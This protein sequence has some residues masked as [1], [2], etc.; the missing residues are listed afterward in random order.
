[1]SAGDLALESHERW[2]ARSGSR[3]P[4]DGVFEHRR[5]RAVVFGRGDQQAL[6]VDEGLF[7]FR[8]VVWHPLFAFE[9]S[10]IAVIPETLSSS[11]PPAL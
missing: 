1:V 8:A 11:P 5:N 6:M 10:V 4:I 7:E 2:L 9:V 3:H